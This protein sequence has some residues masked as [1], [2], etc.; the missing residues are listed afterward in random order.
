MV[1]TGARNHVGNP[2][3]GVFKY[4]VFDFCIK[5]LKVIGI[6]FAEVL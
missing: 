1:Y 2:Q 4:N 6:L 5:T 3:L